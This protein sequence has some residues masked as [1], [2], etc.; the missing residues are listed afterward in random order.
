MFKFGIHSAYHFISI[1]PLHTEFLGFSWT[2]KK[3]ENV[4][5][6]FLVLPFGLSTAPYIFTKLTRPLIAKWRGEGK[7]VSMFLDAGWGCEREFLSCSDVA[8]SIKKDL[9]LSG[10]VPKMRSLYGYQCRLFNFSEIC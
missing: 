4:Y 2:D 6:K 3:G 10:F 9:I 7:M 5:Y 8:Y 1:F